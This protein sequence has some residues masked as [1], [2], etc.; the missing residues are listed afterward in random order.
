M[1]RYALTI[2]SVCLYSAL[3]FDMQITPFLRH[4]TSSPQGCLSLPYFSTLS[5]KWYNFWKKVIEQ[6]NV[7]FQFLYKFV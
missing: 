4:I 6:K 3:L 7:L 1:K 2:V 5:H